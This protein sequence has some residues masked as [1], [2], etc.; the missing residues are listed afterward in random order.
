MKHWTRNASLSL[1]AA[2]T[3]TA[4]GSTAVAF[5]GSDTVLNNKPLYEVR[6]AAGTGEFNLR[7]GKSLNAAFRQPSSLLYVPEEG[8]FLVA[9]TLNQRLRSVSLGETKAVAGMDIGYDEFNAPQGALADGPV[10]KAAFNSPAGL[11]ID[12]AGNV[13]IAD[14]E[15]NAVRMIDRDGKVTTIAGTGEIGLK[16]GAAKFAQLYHPLDVAVTKNGIVYVADTLNHVIRIIEGGNVKTIGTASTRSVQYTPGAV[17]A[18]GDFADGSF[19]EAKFNEPSGLAL[20]VQGNLYVSDTGNQRIRYVDFAKGTVTTAAGGKSGQ[21]VVYAADSPYAQGGY[22]D[23]N[24]PDARFYSPR[25]LTVTP[26][27]GLLIA[28]SL[29]HVIRYL[30]DGRVSTVAGF[31]GE[32][33]KA[34]GLAMAAQFNKPIDVAWMGNGRIGVADSGSNRILIISPYTVPPGV[35]DSKSPQLLYNS[36]LLQPDVAPVTI[37]NSIF[38]PLRVLTE[39]LGFKVEYSG[40]KT[41]LTRGSDTYTVQTGS[42]NVVKSSE[43]EAKQSIKLTSAPFN[44]KNRIFLPVRFFAEEMGLDVQW[45]PEIHAVLLRDKRF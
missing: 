29:N 43:G 21:A 4:F 35:K 20:D 23:G 5:A 18:A 6:T 38:V 41:K 24:A 26:D 30:K 27:G 7:D 36:S 37:N 15:N 17:E 39:K 40:G 31:P 25:G 13:Y 19:S 2:I 16:D 10:D 3:L 44:K 34:D 22:A 33:G 14:S 32:T 11:A 28:D 45:L 1:A 9:D 12:N 8:S 42:V